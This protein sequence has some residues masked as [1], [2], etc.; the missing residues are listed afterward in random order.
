MPHSLR[1]LYAITDTP[2]ALQPLIEQVS[3]AIGGGVR[4]LQYRDKSNDHPRRREQA[5]ALKAVCQRHQIPLIIND[6]IELALAVEADGVHLGKDDDA[7]THARQRLGS[8]IIG[9]SCYNDWSRAEAAQ[10]G[11]ADYIAFGA[12]FPSSTKPNAP[13]ASIDLLQRARAELTIPSVAIGGIT[14]ANGGALIHAGADMLAVVNGLFGQAD[15]SN[16]ARQYA[17]LFSTDNA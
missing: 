13:R 11:G 6:D 17:E 16:A 15:I 12:F 3:A 7:L 14:P 1:G 9:I 4:I 5:S 8:R 10:A 2:L